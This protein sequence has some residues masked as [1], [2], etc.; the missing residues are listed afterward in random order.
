MN[1]ARGV[2]RGRVAA[3]AIVVGVS[4]MLAACRASPPAAAD[5]QLPPLPGPEDVDGS[6]DRM[7][8]GERWPAIV[9][10]EAPAKGAAQPLVTIVEYSDFECPFCGAFAQTLDELVAAY[11]DDVRVVFQQFP[12]SM[13]PGAEPAARASIAA[14]AQGRF[15]VMHDRLFA[16]RHANGTERLVEIADELGLDEAKFAADL[17]AEATA[18]RVRDEQA[19][20]REIGVRST[21]N[22]FINGRRVEGALKPEALQRLVELERQGAQQLVDAGSARAQVYARYMRAA[23]DQHG[24]KKAR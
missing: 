6:L 12:L 24:G 8:E 11:P 1:A 13:H 5:P 10:A 9:S 19:K 21:P 14:Q 23:V 20:G 16:E 3:A 18:Q 15:W 22:F 7:V 4:L 17:E 2:G